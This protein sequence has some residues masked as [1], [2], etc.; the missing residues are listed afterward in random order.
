[1]PSQVLIVDAV[2]KG[3]TGSSSASA[4]RRSSGQQLQGD[5]VAPQNAVELVADTIGEVLHGVR[6]GADDN[7]FAIGG[8]SLTA[9]QV[10][11]RLNDALHVD[12]PDVTFR[13][14]TVR[15][16]RSR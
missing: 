9:T 14:P 5:Y 8:D 11:T 15:N 1:M 16:W 6:V 13:K 3:P 4:W 10:V 12:L 7:F 2:P